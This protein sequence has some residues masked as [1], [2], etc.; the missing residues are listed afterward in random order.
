MRL[1][2]NKIL[3]YPSVLGAIIVG[4]GLALPLLTRHN[5]QKIAVSRLVCSW[6]IISWVGWEPSRNLV[7]RG[8][9]RAPPVARFF[10]ETFV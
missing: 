6:S 8:E 3:P 2:E 10:F 9:K 4:A 1:G 7:I 5:R